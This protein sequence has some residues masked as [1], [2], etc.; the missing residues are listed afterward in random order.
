MIEKIEILQ[1]GE[2]RNLGCHPCDSQFELLR[3][4]AMFFVVI[5]HLVING[6][7]TVGL[8][9]PYNV[10]NDGIAGV[11]IH[12]SVVGGVNLFIMITGWYGVKKH[13]EGCGK[14]NYRLCFFWRCKLSIA[15]ASFMSFPN[16]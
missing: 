8:L 15:F 2:C 16:Y 13:L 10:E 3:I 6:A 12:S 1:H 4:I 14:T 11:I 5:G 9:T 7:N